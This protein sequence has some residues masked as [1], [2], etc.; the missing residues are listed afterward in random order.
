MKERCERL[1]SLKL[2][3]LSWFNQDWKRM[4][5]W[6]MSLLCKS[7]SHITMSV[8]PRRYLG[9]EGMGRGMET[10]CSYYLSQEN[11]T[12]FT[13]SHFFHSYFQDKDQS[14]HEVLS[15]Y[16]SL[17]F[18]CLTFISVIHA[19]WYII[20]HPPVLLS[21]FFYKVKY[22]QIDFINFKYHTLFYW[23]VLSTTVL[24]SIFESK[25]KDFIKRNFKNLRCKCI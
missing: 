24:T 11:S 5:S 17:S 21:C 2:R 19:W 4:K 8:L 23:L 14:F 16:I 12:S 6:K 7:R 20:I 18:P 13:H 15:E 25:P 1:I 3:L 10:V 22:I 9:F